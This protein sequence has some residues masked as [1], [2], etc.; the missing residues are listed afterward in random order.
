MIPAF[1]YNNHPNAAEA[2]KTNV[3]PSDFLSIEKCYML[4]FLVHY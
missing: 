2:K 3:L 4:E 1:R